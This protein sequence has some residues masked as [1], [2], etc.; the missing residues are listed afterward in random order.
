MLAYPERSR[1]PPPV[2]VVDTD[3]WLLNEATPREYQHLRE[4]TA[5]SDQPPPAFASDLAP[6]TRYGPCLTLLTLET[7][8]SGGVQSPSAPTLSGLATGFDQTESAIYRIIHREDNILLKLNIEQWI[9]NMICRRTLRFWQ[10]QGLVP[11]ACVR[12]WD[13]TYMYS[14]DQGRCYVMHGW[15]PKPEYLCAGSLCFMPQYHDDD[16]VAKA[17]TD[18]SQTNRSLVSSCCHSVMCTL[19]ASGE[20]PDQALLTKS[21]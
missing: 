9:A 18:L 12:G 7:V 19:W 17:N 2:I 21:S 4:V 13:R 11:D 16:T 6:D 15:R 10:R 8:I 5:E 20:R 14:H 1:V 3:H